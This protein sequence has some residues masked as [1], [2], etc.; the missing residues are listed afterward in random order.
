MRKAILLSIICAVCVPAESDFHAPLVAVAR[1]N[2]KQL[3]IVYGVT[4]NFILRDV[5]AK[6]VLSWTFSGAGGLVQTRSALLLLDQNGRITRSIKAPEGPTLLS[7]GTV[8]LPA[9]Y[10]SSA[11]SQFRQVRAETDQDVALEPEALAGDLVAL[12]AISRNRAEL[13]VC[14]DRDFWLLTVKLGDG[15]IEREI[16]LGGSARAAACGTAKTAAVL[17]MNGSVVVASAKEI[18]IQ[19]A[20]GMERRIELHRREQADGAFQI[21]QAGDGWIEVDPE[22]E[23]PLL[24]RVSGAGEG[25]YRLPNAELKQ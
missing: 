4:G 20:G 22:K 5:I 6:D 8:T 12:R 16:A 21:R 14:R 18:I 9:L 2:V 15:S 24:V 1:D 17:L 25:I 13:A 3:R 19:N 7:P 23:S 10:F 11:N